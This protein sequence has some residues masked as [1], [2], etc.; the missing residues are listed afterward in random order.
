VPD[1]GAAGYDDGL[2]GAAGYMMGFHKLA[3]HVLYKVLNLP[4]HTA[5]V[6]PLREL[7]TGRLPQVPVICRARIDPIACFEDLRADK[8]KAVTNFDQLYNCP[9][10]VPVFT[11]EE[12]LK[13]MSPGGGVNGNGKRGRNGGDDGLIPIVGN[14][15]GEQDDFDTDKLIFVGISYN[16]GSR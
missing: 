14:F 10:N 16:A 4:C 12:A 2:R 11:T 1:G 3:T 8:A 9:P 6:T 5:M 15:F 7:C 13:G